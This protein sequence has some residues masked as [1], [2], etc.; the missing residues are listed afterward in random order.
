[1]VEISERKN[2]IKKVLKVKFDRNE[3]LGT[4]IASTKNSSR[5]SPKEKRNKGN[6]F[7]V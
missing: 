7:L 6:S 2:V 4:M 5:S 1:M 3:N